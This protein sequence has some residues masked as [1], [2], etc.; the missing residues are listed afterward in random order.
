MACCH[1]ATS[2]AP[3]HPNLHHSTLPS[4]LSRVQSVDPASDQRR[5][6][7]TNALWLWELPQQTMSVLICIYIII[8]PFWWFLMIRNV[9]LN[10]A[11]LFTGEGYND[12]QK[13][14]KEC[15]HMVLLMWT[16][17][18]GTSGW[19]SNSK[20]SWWSTP[21]NAPRKMAIL[22]LSILGR[23]HSHKYCE[24]CDVKAPQN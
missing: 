23:G 3:S 12:Y 7:L 20:A 2:F 9:N 4:S 13:W 14:C 19:S 16:A 10:Q 8:Y 17:S 6:P 15:K 24:D 21:K 1:A 11:C 22:G 18:L 5:N